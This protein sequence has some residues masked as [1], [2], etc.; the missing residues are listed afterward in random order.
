[1]IKAILNSVFLPKCYTGKSLESEV[2][3]HMSLPHQGY[4]SY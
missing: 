1:M 3:G 2:Y 4:Q